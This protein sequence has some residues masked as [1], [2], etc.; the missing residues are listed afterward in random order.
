MKDSKKVMIIEDDVDIREALSDMLE[1]EG[2][3]TFKAENGFEA[4]KSLKKMALK[5]Q[6]PSL[7]LLDL[8]MPVMDGIT[9]IKEIESNYKEFKKI[10]I[11]VASANLDL[12]TN[13]NLDLAVEKIPKPL[14][15]DQVYNV[16][17]RHCR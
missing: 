16:V 12:T 17:K 15:I 10:P 5:Q 2:Y 14:D 1:M 11:V 13:T 4:L 9:F 7:I 6:A 3:L 8:M